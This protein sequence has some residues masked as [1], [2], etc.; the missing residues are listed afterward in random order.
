MKKI[1]ETNAESITWVIFTVLIIIFF[2]F[3]WHVIYTLVTNSCDRFANIW[4]S[5][6]DVGFTVYEL[7]FW[8]F[9]L[10][11]VLSLIE[12]IKGVAG[13][14]SDRKLCISINS[15]I[16]VCVV[17]CCYTQYRLI[18]YMQ[19]EWSKK[20]YSYV[21]LPPHIKS[22]KAN[23]VYRSFRHA[24]HCRGETPHRYPQTVEDA[25]RLRKEFQESGLVRLSN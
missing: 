13:L 3:Q 6:R 5:D 22:L 16:L 15:L 10:I 14:V 19:L 7:T 1:K 2:I 4:L 23:K 21:Y 18:D 8:I 17:A 20:E 25:E 24:K 11:G 9:F 12:L